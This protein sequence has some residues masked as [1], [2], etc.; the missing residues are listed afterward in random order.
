[1]NPMPLKTTFNTLKFN[2]DASKE[3]V[4]QAQHWKSLDWSAMSLPPGIGGFSRQ[5]EDLV[6]QIAFLKGFMSWETFL[7]ESFILYL[8]GTPPPIGTPPTRSIIPLDREKAEKIV[9]EGK[10]YA[11]WTTADLVIQR[12]ERFFATGGPYPNALKIKKPTLEEIKK[13]R[14]AVA[15]PS[16]YGQDEFKKIVRNKLGSY[17]PGLTV[18]Q[19][20]TM[21]IPKSS[22]PESFLEFYVDILL[23]LA[24][25]IVPT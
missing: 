6:A 14:N 17:P 21:T 24:Q 4:Y 5:H 1:M 7:E 20:L 13:I 9:A 11:D 22:P 2:L 10:Q 15:H 12:S 25:E 19:F 18:G 3:F 8:L 16:T 23:F